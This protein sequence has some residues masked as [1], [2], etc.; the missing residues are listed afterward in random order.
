MAQEISR[1]GHRER[2]REQYIKNGI[3]AMPDHIILE[4]ILFYAIP[5]RDVKPIAYNLL[6]HF[7]QSLDAVLSADI[8]E[9]CKVDGIGRNAAVLI[10][11]FRDVNNVVNIRKNSNTTEIRNWLAA[12]DYAENELSHLKKE[13][14]IL[15]TL[16]NSMQIIKCHTVAE[17]TV[18]CAKIQVRNVVEAVLKDNAS[19]VILAH[20]HPEGSYQP[21]QE[22]LDLTSSLK[23][24]LSDLDVALNDHIIVGCNGSLSIMNDKRYKHYLD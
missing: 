1:E 12:K 6:N 24:M 8:D 5:R 11:L 10:R 17:G 14:V 2:T 23:Y 21:S 20:N 16:N 22:D 7:D 13:R 9:L 3:E 19:S 18:N 15:I 4:L